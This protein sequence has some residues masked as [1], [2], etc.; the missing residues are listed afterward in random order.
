MIEA[1]PNGYASTVSFR[2]AIPDVIRLTRYEK[3]SEKDVKYTRENVYSHYGNFCGYCGKK[4]DTKD[5][6]LDHVMPRSRGGKTNWSNM[7]L[8]CIPCNSRKA[9]RTP[10]EAGMKL[11]VTLGRP[12]WKGTQRSLFP[13]PYGVKESW[14]NFIDRAYWTSELEHD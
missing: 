5:L 13:E 7:A 2:L 3:L 14:Q 6:N 9:A 11:L 4:F 8:S 12:K 1:H 10:E